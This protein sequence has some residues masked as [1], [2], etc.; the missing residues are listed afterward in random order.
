VAEE[1]DRDLNGRQA[2]TLPTPVSSSN[3]LDMT[4]FH[5]TRVVIAPIG[6]QRVNDLYEL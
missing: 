3:G 1:P 2:T 6:V 4:Q 5:R